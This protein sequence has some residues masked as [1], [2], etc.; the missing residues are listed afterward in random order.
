MKNEKKL[1]LVDIDQFLLRNGLEYNQ[2]VLRILFKNKYKI[3]IWNK[4]KYEETDLYMFKKINKRFGLNLNK[5][6]LSNLKRDYILTFANILARGQQIEIKKGS[7]NRVN[8]LLK[9]EKNVIGGY[10]NSFFDIVRLKLI[11]LNLFH[12][13]NLGAYGEDADNLDDLL[14]IA[15]KIIEIRQKI[16]FSDE[17]LF[18]LSTNIRK[19]EK[20]KK[21]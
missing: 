13:Y 8:D 4:I 3:S 17:N 1:I 19:V 16:K 15:R 6:D 14:L 21:I 11:P 12:I 5:E 20:F 2:H 18:Y 7:Q 9:D 10:S